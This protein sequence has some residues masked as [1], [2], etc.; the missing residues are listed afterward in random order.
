M[1]D[2]EEDFFGAQRGWKL[3]RDLFDSSFHPAIYI[4]GD[5]WHIE[6]LGASEGNRG[7]RN[8]CDEFGD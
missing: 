7:E 1:S 4:V 2:F 8:G 3:G 5:R 6:D